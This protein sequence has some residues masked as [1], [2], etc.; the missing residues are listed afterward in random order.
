M[1]TRTFMTLLFL[2]ALLILGQQLGAQK[3]AVIPYVS[4]I[5]API[6]IKQCGDDR[7]FVLERGGR[8]RIVNADGTLRPTPFLDITA[9]ISSAT[10]GEEGL[11]GLDFSPDYKSS[12]KF[13]VDYT[14]YIGTQLTTFVE[15]YSVS[16]SDSNLADPASALTL[17][18]QSQPFTNHNGGNL[19]FGRDGYL[20]INFGDGGSAGDPFRNGQNLKTFLGKILRIDVRNASPAQPYVI[21][22]DNPLAQDTATGVKKEIWIYGVRNPFRSSFDR[23]T[24]DLLVADVGQNK[25]EEVDYRPAGDPGGENFGWNIV[26]GDSCYSPATGCD[27]TGITLP[28]YEYFHNGGGAAIIGGYVYRS[29]Q[30]RALWGQ[31]LFSDEILRFIDGL[32]IVNGAV[33][34]GVHPLITAAAATG[35]PVSFGE[36]RLGDQYIAFYGINQIY[37]LEDTSSL[38]RPKAYFTPVPGTGGTYLLE[39][40]Q[41]R[42][43]E[44]QWFRNDT[45]LPGAT[46]PDLTASQTGRYTL[47]VTN[48]LGFSDTSEAFLLGTYGNLVDFTAQKIPGSLVL[49]AWQ[50]TGELNVTGFAIE[51][52]LEGETSFGDIGLLASQAPGGYSISP[53]DYA[54]R[55][56]TLPPSSPAFYRL[57]VTF[58]D[59]SFAYSDTRFV[60]PDPST[61]GFIVFPNPARHH[62]QLYLDQYTHPVVLSV[63]D[64]AG[65]KLYGLDLQ[66]AG[67]IIDLPASTGIYV[68]QVSD[69]DGRHAFRRKVVVY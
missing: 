12:G 3:L 9:K 37:R 45:L 52:R 65:R 62:L 67:R 29:I 8:I 24:G 53:L 10:E 69:P 30:S 44:Y 51:R 7:L 15:Q 55:D 49:L 68:I 22:P 36:D 33:V 46:A 28:V 38:R 6:D 1:G 31:Y 61:N 40:L 58:R 5:T 25:V 57:R 63:F 59:G 42:N 35:N 14:G 4:G 66:Q 2:P 27:K 18:T 48:T 34:G 54:F 64:L 16:A 17:L 32:S 21:P 13:Y 20:Y 43:M 60:S 19:M 26:E 23:I 11:L 39:A 50:T 47:Q 41:G 56:S